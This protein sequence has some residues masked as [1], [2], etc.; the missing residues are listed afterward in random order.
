[1]SFTCLSHVL[2]MSSAIKAVIVAEALSVPGAHALL[3]IMESY[4][5]ATRIGPE[6]NRYHLA[7]TDKFTRAATQLQ[8]KNLR[9]KLACTFLNSPRLPSLRD[10]A[11]SLPNI[12]AVLSAALLPVAEDICGDLCY[13]PSPPGTNLRR[14]RQYAFEVRTP[15]ETYIFVTGQGG[16]NATVKRT[17]ILESY[18]VILSLRTA[19]LIRHVYHSAMLAV[20]PQP[21]TPTPYVLL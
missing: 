19:V 4:F 15:S 17:V 8:V 7:G 13:N 18:K 6:S 14:G 11:K 10:Y 21:P 12:H 5:K 3:Q 1:M 2:H 16:Q 20:L 9:D